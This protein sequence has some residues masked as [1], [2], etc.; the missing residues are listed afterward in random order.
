[1]E[2]S[3]T[4]SFLDIGYGAAGERRPG[5][6]HRRQQLHHP[7]AP[8]PASARARAAR[9]APV[10]DAPLVAPRQDAQLL[11]GEKRPRHRLLAARA[12][13]PAA[14]SARTGHRE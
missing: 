8:G 7:Q 14:A 10:R 13:E 5:A 1:M 11:R 6:S 4:V 3:N 2:N 9:R 12:C